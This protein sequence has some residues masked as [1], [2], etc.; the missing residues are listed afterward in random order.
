MLLPKAV[1]QQQRTPLANLPVVDGDV[2]DLHGR[3]WPHR[4]RGLGLAVK[5]EAPRRA[6][7]A[8]MRELRTDNHSRNAP[9]LAINTRLGYRRLPGW[10]EVVR[11]PDA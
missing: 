6:K 9:M 5:V 2:T 3:G 11:I 4:G 1:D 7:A 8:G 10:I